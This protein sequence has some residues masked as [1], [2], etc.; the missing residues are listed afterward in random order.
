LSGFLVS[1]HDPIPISIHV[2]THGLD[3]EGG[4]LTNAHGTNIC[5]LTNMGYSQSKTW[6]TVQHHISYFDPDDTEVNHLFVYTEGAAFVPYLEATVRVA[7][8]GSILKETRGKIIFGCKRVHVSE[9]LEKQ[10]GEWKAVI[11]ITPIRE[12]FV[13]DEKKPYDPN[14]DLEFNLTI[15]AYTCGDNVYQIVAGN[16]TFE[17]KI[18]SGIRIL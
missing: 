8:N 4:E 13:L 2:D 7:L 11:T 6:A 5:N 14:F 18:N 17:F 9:K 12:S 1:D 10:N 3:L 16:K 15:H